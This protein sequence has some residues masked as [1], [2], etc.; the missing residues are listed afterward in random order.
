MISHMPPREGQSAGHHQDGTP[1]CGNERPNIGWVAGSNAV[2][3]NGD[4]DNG[5]VDGI[6]LASPRAQD[7]CVLAQ[8]S[9][10]RPDVYGTK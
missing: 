4:S 2:A 10:Y 9:I 1:T 6:A 5:C 7:P 3:P 8:S